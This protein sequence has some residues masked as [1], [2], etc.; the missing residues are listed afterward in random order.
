RR[1]DLGV[2]LI[3]RDLEER[4]VPPHHFAGAL[5]PADQRTLGDAL[6]HLRHDDF[7]R[8]SALREEWK[9]KDYK[10]PQSTP[11]T[12]LGTDTCVPHFRK[13]GTEVSVPIYRALKFA[14]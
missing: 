13:M 10:K 1:R 12:K 9:T 2:H 11:A 5:Q 7:H 8:H 3:G 14:G 6:A 4:L